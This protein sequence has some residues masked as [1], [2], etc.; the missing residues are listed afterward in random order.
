MKRGRGG[1]GK[2]NDKGAVE[3]EK[4]R[5]TNSSSRLEQKSA[6]LIL[7]IGIR[8]EHIGPLLS[9]GFIVTCYSIDTKLI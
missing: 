1:D 9:R 7:R 4:V 8:E 3:V 5:E 6:L 2:R